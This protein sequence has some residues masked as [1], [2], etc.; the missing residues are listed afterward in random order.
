MN[1]NTR[2]LPADVLITTRGDQL[3]LATDPDTPLKVKGFNYFPRMHPWAI[4]RQW[5]PKAVREEM[6]IAARM[7]SNVIRTFI[8]GCSAPP[9][10][11]LY[12]VLEFVRICSEKGQKV[13]P[14]FF[15]GCNDYSPA[16]SAT[17]KRNLQQLQAVVSA[18]EG[19][20]AILAWDLRNEPDWISHSLWSWNMGGAE[21]IAAR[22]ID[23]LYRMAREVRRI[24][25]RHLVTVG[26]VFDYNNHQPE[27]IRT[28]ESFVDLVCFHY[29]TRNYR[30]RTLQQAIR[31]MKRHTK[32]PINV[33]EIGHS[34]KGGPDGSPED[35][36]RWFREWMQAVDEED[37][38]GIIQWNLSEWP[39]Q[40]ETSDEERY[41]GFLRPDGSWRPAAE[42]FRDMFPVPQF[43]PRFG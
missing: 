25:P 19:D 37:I 29:Y 21:E 12:A 42:V 10:D 3:V 11:Q 23:W 30:D 18:L 5:D 41:Y 15:D 34:A 14:T 20:P 1:T 6:A 17:E 24:S 7:G 39:P 26:L 35:Q 31:D 13:I 33:Q 36:A 43:E 22:R 4:F 9:T 40:F 2:L 32:K 8:G 28:I 27:N 38:T 16:G